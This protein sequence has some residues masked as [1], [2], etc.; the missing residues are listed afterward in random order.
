LSEIHAEE[1]YRLRYDE[2][3]GVLASGRPHVS[4]ATVRDGHQTLL[5]REILSLPVPASDGFT[6][7]VMVASFWTD[8]RRLN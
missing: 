8:R 3:N 1:G 6:R 4:R 2:L 5:S 7:L